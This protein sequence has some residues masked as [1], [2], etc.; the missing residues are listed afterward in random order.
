MNWILRINVKCRATKHVCINIYVYR[1]L[2]AAVNF[3]SVEFCGINLLTQLTQ[4]RLG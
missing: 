4:I 2:D 3:N 1:Y